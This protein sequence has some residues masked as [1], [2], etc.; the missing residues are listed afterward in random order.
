MRNIGICKGLRGRYFV[1][2][3]VLQFRDRSK[4]SESDIDSLFRGFLRLLK[5]MINESIENKYIARIKS[6]ERELNK[7]KGK[8]Q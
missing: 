8:S 5:V 1:T 2:P 6:L 4:V 7:Y 3:K